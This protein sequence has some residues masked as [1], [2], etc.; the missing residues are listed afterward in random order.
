MKKKGNKVTK[1]NKSRKRERKEENE[2]EGN[3]RKGDS[4]Q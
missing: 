1:K 2:T 4:G 3:E